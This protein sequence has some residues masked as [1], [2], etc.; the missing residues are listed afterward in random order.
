MSGTNA[1]ASCHIPAWFG[2]PATGTLPP[3]GS[4]YIQEARPEFVAGKF[5]WAGGTGSIDYVAVGDDVVRVDYAAGTA[6][7]LVARLERYDE[8][9]IGEPPPVSGPPIVIGIDHWE[10]TGDF[11]CGHGSTADITFDRPVAAFHAVWTMP[12]STGSCLFADKILASRTVDD[13][14][15][16]RLGHLGCGTAV[17]PARA[18]PGGLELTL[19]A[20]E[21]DG[22]ETRILGVPSW[23]A[24]DR[25]IARTTWIDRMARAAASCP[26]YVWGL[27]A[28]GLAALVAMTSRTARKL[29]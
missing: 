13:H 23:S 15:E 29:T 11:V 1:T 7:T 24:L 26:L 28:I 6:H 14:S 2:V 12:C 5:R 9:T 18:W 3:R 10:Y 21:F 17:G 16:L 20:I 25:A 22:R 27:L 4:L 19:T 8:F